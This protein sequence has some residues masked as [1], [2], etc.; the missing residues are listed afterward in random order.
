LDEPP[1]ELFEPPEPEV[2]V[3]PLLEL[4]LPLLDPELAP[5]LAAALG[6]MAR[7]MGIVITYCDASER[8]VEL[9]RVGSLR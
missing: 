6:S 2:E 7:Q 8:S 3:P 5:P 1:V 9:L 4:E